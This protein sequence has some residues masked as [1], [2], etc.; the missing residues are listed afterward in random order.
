M[1]FSTRGNNAMPEND[2]AAEAIKQVSNL[3]Q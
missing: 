2:T 1:R 3:L